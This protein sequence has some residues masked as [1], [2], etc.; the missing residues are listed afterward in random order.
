MNKNISKFLA[1]FLVLGLTASFNSATYAMVIPVDPV[2]NITES[3][4]DSNIEELF[5]KYEITLRNNKITPDT[6]YNESNYFTK[7][8]KIN[9]VIPDELKEELKSTF[10]TIEEYSYNKMYSKE[11][12]MDSVEESS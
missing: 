8:I 2:E 7:K 4:V 10:F 6:Y 1:S 5:K 9:I 11:I 3:T 12:M